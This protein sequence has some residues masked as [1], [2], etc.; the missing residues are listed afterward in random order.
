MRAAIAR[1]LALAALFCL[2]AAS[3]PDELDELRAKLRERDFRPGREALQELAKLGTPGA[4]EIA[5]DALE[6]RR[7]QI[8][9]EAQLQLGACS[10]PETI[11]LLL[12]KRGLASGK[13]QVRLR[14]SELVGRLPVEVDGEALARALKD[15]DPQVR[16]NLC[17]S[18]E[19]LA[20]AGRLGEAGSKKLRS[21]LDK[22]LGKDRE[23]GVRGAA[24][25][26]RAAMEP[27]AATMERADR[28]FRNDDPVV[29]AAALVAWRHLR[30][31]PVRYDP[32]PILLMAL[33]DE[34]SSVRAVA[35][36]ELA[37]LAA[38]GSRN[39][40][41]G[42]VD[43]LEIETELRLR[44]LIVGHLQ[45]LSGLKHRLDH[46]PWK[47]WVKGL[48]DGWTPEEAEPDREAATGTVSFAGLPILSERI[49]FLID[50]S[51]S[52]WEEVE[53]GRTRKQQ[54]DGELRAALER[55]AP[56]AELN[57]IPYTDRPIPWKKELVPAKPASV[58]QALKFFEGRKESGVGDLW[59]AVLLAL[60]DPRSDTLI[61]LHD[62]SPTGGIGWN[63]DLFAALFAER[64]RFRAVALDV[65][66]VRDSGFLRRRWQEI[67]ESTGGRFVARDE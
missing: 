1:T 58:A 56:E 65:V 53:E 67:S 33:Q 42:L 27:G 5:L 13:P 55:L 45:R 26:A 34:A 8:A 40:A 21:A 57:L 51:G 12:G 31:G 10:D 19:R 23:A 43:A 35:Q 11:E 25:V 64:N 3:G 9:D 60:S 6:D 16:R 22:A 18:L 2:S 61:V 24:L 32:P 39:A 36:R 38:D 46:R 17:W 52:M 14:V 66:L 47:G 30:G 7:S 59:E 29:R 41:R 49:A 63:V 54:V 15:K 20:A 44:W 62:G 28:A 50:L 48:E 4:W 37:L